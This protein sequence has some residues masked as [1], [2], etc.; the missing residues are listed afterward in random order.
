MRKWGD[1]CR[2]V[3]ISSGF[4][5]KSLI[6]R[7]MDECKSYKLNILIYSIFL[8]GWFIL[9]YNIFYIILDQVVLF[10]EKFSVSEFSFSNLIGRRKS[11]R[12]VKK[13]KNFKFP[14]RYINF[15]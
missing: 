8:S 9:V 4:K 12:I 5:R 3:A 13:R 1:D 15:D 11:I 14:A 7:G 6:L 10:T 2:E